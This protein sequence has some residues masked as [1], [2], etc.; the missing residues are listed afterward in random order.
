MISA[1][2]HTHIPSVNF[3]FTCGEGYDDMVTVGTVSDDDGLCS[4]SLYCFVNIRGLG[5]LSAMLITTLLP[6]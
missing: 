2:A 6:D 5:D 1:N 4:L 3:R